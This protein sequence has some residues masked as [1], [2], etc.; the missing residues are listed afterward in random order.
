MRQSWFLQRV[1]QWQR[2]FFQSVAT[3]T[4]RHPELGHGNPH[5]LIETLTGGKT[6]AEESQTHS[7]IAGLSSLIKS[8][9][10]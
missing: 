1:N 9:I 2:I 8:L 4:F 5:C 6:G 3:L 7:L 10:Y